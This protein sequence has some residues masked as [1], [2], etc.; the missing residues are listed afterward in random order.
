MPDDALAATDPAE[1]LLDVLDDDGAFVDTMPR[2]VVHAQGLWHEVFHCLVIR[3]SAPPRLLLQRRRRAARAFPNLLDVS[4]AGH[5]SAGERPLD[6][7]RE[8]REE[9][10][11]DVDPARLVPVALR[12]LIDD[13]GEGRNREIAHVYLLVDDTPLEELTLDP[14]EVEGFVELTAASLQRIVA[15]G[16]AREPGREVDT[17]GVVRDVTIS[18]ADLVPDVDDYWSEL[19]SAAHAHIADTIH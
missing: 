12:R 2:S 13:G 11:L 14:D 4:V 1:E 17:G 8:I 9:L 19:A 16:A 3:S 5:L 7:V 18:S 15:D 6:G 10:G